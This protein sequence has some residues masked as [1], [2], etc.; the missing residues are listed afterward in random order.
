MT[1]EALELLFTVTTSI[2]I[3]SGQKQL[4]IPVPFLKE[5]LL[6]VVSILTT[7][8]FPATGLLLTFTSILNHPL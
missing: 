8:L 5:M 7:G 4:L 3:A 2:Y 6:A 1:S